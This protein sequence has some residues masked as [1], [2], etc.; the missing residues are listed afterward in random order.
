MKISFVSISLLSLSPLISASGDWGYGEHNGPHHWG[1][2]S[3]AFKVCKTGKRQ[4]PIALKEYETDFITHENYVS[5]WHNTDQN[6]AYLNNGHAISVDLSNVQVP[7][8]K[9]DCHELGLKQ[10]H[11]HTPSE[12]IING[13][14]ADLEAHF[15]FTD[16]QS[17]IFQVFGVL[18]NLDLLLGDHN[19]FFKGIT[20]NNQPIN[21]K[22]RKREF[23]GLELGN[24]YKSVHGF[25]SGH[26]YRGSLTT[27]PCTETARFII[28]NRILPV[29]LRQLNILKNAVHGNNSRPIQP[30]NLEHKT[31]NL[32][33]QACYK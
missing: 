23:H 8:F 25:Q 3:E 12:H 30:T 10:F 9:L 32:D 2:I 7:S 17:N 18:F 20:Q 21:E 33:I 26:V 16:K 11:L 22:D 5:E 4:S 24:L 13:K 28:S 29:S 19:G 27:P 31:G 14:R 15:V 6:L 1:S